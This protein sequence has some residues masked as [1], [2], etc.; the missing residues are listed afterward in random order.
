MRPALQRE[1]TSV[2]ATTSTALEIEEA[3][4]FAGS[5]FGGRGLLR[6]S[7]KMQALFGGSH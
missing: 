3:G 6:S 4:E 7:Q 5:G 2:C 1:T